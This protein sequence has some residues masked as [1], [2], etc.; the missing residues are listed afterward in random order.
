MSMAPL[1]DFLLQKRFMQASANYLHLDIYHGDTETTHPYVHGTLEAEQIVVPAAVATVA[2]AP[3]RPLFVAHP[4]TAPI[5]T[6][7]AITMR[8]QAIRDAAMRKAAPG[9]SPV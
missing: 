7:A 9:Q 2:P 6:G 1:S 3:V 4:I 8:Y 5:S